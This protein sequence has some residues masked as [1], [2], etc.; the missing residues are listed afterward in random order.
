MSFD[1][2][3]A[4]CCFF[5]G[6]LFCNCFYM[7]M[8]P[9]WNHIIIVPKSGIPNGNHLNNDEVEVL[10]GSFLHEKEPRYKASL[11]LGWLTKLL[12]LPFL[13]INVVSFFPHSY[14]TTLCDHFYVV[15]YRCSLGCVIWLGIALFGSGKYLHTYAIPSILPYMSSFWLDS[16]SM[17]IMW[18]VR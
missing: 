15:I 18:H 14:R 11:C 13:P 4:F 8:W 6:M 9:S 5:H 2:S 17:V 3:E 10:P 12:V 7:C 1:S 16:D